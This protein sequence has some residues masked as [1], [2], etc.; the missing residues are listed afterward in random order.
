MKMVIDDNVPIREGAVKC[1]VPRSTLQ[2]RVHGR[3]LPRS[4]SGPKP[5]FIRNEENELVNFLVKSAAI[6]YDRTWEEVIAM[7]E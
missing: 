1:G 2:D 6:G 3:V 5:F 4:V 7:T